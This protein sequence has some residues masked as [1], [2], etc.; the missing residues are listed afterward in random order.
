MLYVDIQEG[1]YSQAEVGIFNQPLSKVEGYV[2][3]WLQE[4]V[5]ASAVIR[6]E[7]GPIC[8]WSRHADH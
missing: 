1:R 6:D 8:E 5:N 7:N 3:D 2:M 4:R